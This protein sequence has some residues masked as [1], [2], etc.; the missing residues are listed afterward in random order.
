MR[1][2]LWIG[3]DATTAAAR[4]LTL[5]TEPERFGAIRYE[6][7]IALVDGCP[8]GFVEVSLRD[9][10][11][12]FAEQTVGYVEGVFVEMEHRRDG[13]GLTLLGAA[14]AWTRAAGAARLVSDVI[15]DN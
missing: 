12:G 5:L 4:D 10:V 7:L 15:G 3:T 14:T 9:D 13:I 2:A 6:A 1:Q 11:A 8:V